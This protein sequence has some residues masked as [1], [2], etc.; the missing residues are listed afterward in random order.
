LATRRVSVI[1]RLAMNTTDLDDE[2]T[3]S[4]GQFLIKAF[5]GASIRTLHLKR[6][7]GS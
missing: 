6:S 5:A 4:R 7:E 2:Y 1:S 3:G